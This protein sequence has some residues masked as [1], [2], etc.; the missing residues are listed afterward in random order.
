MADN[1]IFP[2]VCVPVALPRLPRGAVTC[3]VGHEV[4]EHPRHEALASLSPRARAIFG[5][6]AKLWRWRREGRAGVWAH[7][8]W[9][10]PFAFSLLILVRTLRTTYAM[11]CRDLGTLHT[12]ANNTPIIAPDS[13][14]YNTHDIRFRFLSIDW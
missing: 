6:V 7:P 3:Q 10:D 4:H 2:H 9:R 5:R 11:V 13:T 1:D 14:T 8:F 12:M